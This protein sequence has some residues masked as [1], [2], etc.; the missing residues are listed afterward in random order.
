V[1]DVEKEEGWKRMGRARSWGLRCEEL[2]HEDRNGD[3]DEEV[4]ATNK[5]V[6]I[7]WMWT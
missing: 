6:G 3:G 5:T 2:H 1:V 7:T 4:A